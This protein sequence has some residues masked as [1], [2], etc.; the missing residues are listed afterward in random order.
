MLCLLHIKSVLCR[1]VDLLSAPTDVLNPD[2]WHCV[3]IIQCELMIMK[4]YVWFLGIVADEG[5]ECETR[6]Q[7]DTRR[8]TGNQGSSLLPQ[9]QL[10]ETGEPRSTA[11]VPAKN[12]Q[13]TLLC[14]FES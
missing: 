1:F 3:I 14:V 7:C 2:L 12:C 5:T 8:G 13:Y 10:A 9:Y 11:T 4:L 6:L